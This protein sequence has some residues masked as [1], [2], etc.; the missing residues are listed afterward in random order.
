M[1]KNIS[2]TIKSTGK[3][4]KIIKA[5]HFTDAHVD[6]LYKLNSDNSCPDFLCCRNENGFPSDP[7]RKAMQWGD[8]KC[9]IPSLTF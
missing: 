8:L 1:Y 2:D 7:K 6:T 4:R 9:D 5:V 3:P